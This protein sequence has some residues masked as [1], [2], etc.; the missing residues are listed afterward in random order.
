[1]PFFWKIVFV[2]SNFKLKSDAKNNLS[3]QSVSTDTYDMVIAGRLYDIVRYCKGYISY[4]DEFIACCVSPNKNAY[5]S[6][7]VCALWRSFIISYNSTLKARWSEPAKSSAC[8]CFKSLK[9][10]SVQISKFLK[11][12]G[13]LS[14][15]VTQVPV[16]CPIVLNT[17]QV[18]KCLSALSA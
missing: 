17:L 9:R 15:K 7:K 1:M 16:Q 6:E 12:L 10:P 11:C 2:L 8:K 13:A 5:I 14:T 18:L 3:H 4:E